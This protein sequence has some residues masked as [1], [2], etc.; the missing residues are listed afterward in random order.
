MDILHRV[1]AG[2]DVHKKNVM[3]CVRAQGK[4]KA[5]RETRSFSTETRGLLSLLD[6]LQ[7]CGCT[8]AAM[9]S[10]GVYWKPVW[11]ILEGHLELVLA[12]AAHVRNVPGRKSDV[13]DAE[14]IAD[15]LAHGLIS[16]SFVPPEPIQELRELT[17]TRKQLTREKG[18]HCQRIQRVLEDANVKLASVITDVLGA[19]GRKMLAAIIQGETD[20]E[21]LADFGDKRLKCSREELVESLRGRVTAHHRF[22]LRQH[23]G[24]ICDLE[25]RIGEFDEQIVAVLAPFRHQVEL[26]TTIPGVSSRAAEV[27][28]AE[29]GVD[30]TVF[31]SAA[32][33]VSWAGLCPGLNESAGKRQSTRVRKGAPWLKATLMQ[34]AWAAT[35]AKGTYLQAQFRQIRARRGAKRAAIAVCASILTAMWHMLQRDEP[36]QD[37]GADHFARRDREAKARGLARQLRKLGYHVNLDDAA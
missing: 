9:E 31:P 37:L 34:C 35:R 23:L 18:Q 19:S 10:T 4:Q 6:W 29:V 3:V 12:N 27:I 11:H 30:M 22:L 25:Q 14:W 7:E 20:P 24:M 28:V 16:G 1:C 5:Q 36:W 8:H 17:R 2:L 21:R 33:L 13:K 32:Q 26:L 15:L